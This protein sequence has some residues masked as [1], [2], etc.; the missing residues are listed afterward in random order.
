MLFCQNL[1]KI[2]IDCDVKNIEQGSFDHLNIETIECSLDILKKHFSTE[3]HKKSI[4]EIKLLYIES[5]EDLNLLDQYVNLKTI[6]IDKSIHKLDN[7][8]NPNIRH[9]IVH[10][11]FFNY[12]KKETIFQITIPDWIRDMDKLS[13]EDIDGFYSL[14]SLILPES[15]I[16]CDPIDDFQCIL[17]HI[18]CNVELLPF[19]ASTSLTSLQINEPWG[20]IHQR[21]LEKCIQLQHI[22]ILGP[23]N[24]QETAFDNCRKL[25]E[26]HWV[27][28][29]MFH[30]SD[31]ELQKVV[32]IDNNKPI[33]VND[34]STLTS[35]KEIV[36]PPTIKSFDYNTFSRCTNLTN[37][38]C[39]LNDLN[40]FSPKQLISLTI[41]EGCRKI[42]KNDFDHATNLTKLILPNSI[43]QI[44]DI[45]AFKK[46]SALQSIQCKPQFLKYLNPE[47]ITEYY[48]PDGITAIVT[49]DIQN[50]VNLV[51][52]H[53]PDSIE[54]IESDAFTFC[55]KI[56]K[57]DCKPK[58]FHKF[59]IFEIVIPKQITH[60][61]KGTYD[62][63]NTVSRIII[64][65]N[66]TIIDAEA[67]EECASLK[68]IE[69]KG[70]IK[71]V[72][73][74]AFLNCQSLEKLIVENPIKK[75][76][77]E[78]FKGCRNLKKFECPVELQNIF[79]RE[80]RIDK[81][82]I[83]QNDEYRPFK[84]ILS[85]VIPFH[86]ILIKNKEQE[87]FNMFEHLKTISCR[88]EYLPFVKNK[89]KMATEII[90]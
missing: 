32:L 73:D 27:S 55:K 24:V 5:L 7:I 17:K 3:K 8:S 31:I 82:K 39:N 43:T 75:I 61:T 76:N 79:R 44:E 68:E 38:Q 85:L 77:I 41:N 22:V 52:I 21:D 46:L 33:S 35:L 40:K 88:V 69:L 59:N 28:N 78:A 56:S 49:E 71:E 9:I 57:L 42:F 51:T 81:W 14:K 6:E 50:C 37:V 10:P 26:V 4:K 34:F 12:F 67:F 36:I 30:F 45:E 89:E 2:S 16:Y 54:F 84:N 86:S 63:W 70:K 62:K 1:K 25:T 20:D 58:W 53:L 83:I 11:K 15:I 90:W 29:G 80:L 66:D 72:K 23:K 19:I 74:N 60:I 48:V 65:G 64:E 13:K 87:F 47:N 18:Q